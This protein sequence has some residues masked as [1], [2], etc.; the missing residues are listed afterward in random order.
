MTSEN[1]LPPPV[2]SDHHHHHH[3]HHLHHI[4]VDPSDEEDED[5]NSGYNPPITKDEL[6]QE[7]DELL[8]AFCSDAQQQFCM[9]Q[10]IIL[11]DDLMRMRQTVQQIQT[12]LP[13]VNR[14][15]NLQL[16]RALVRSIHDILQHYGDAC[17]QRRMR[18]LDEVLT[19][20]YI[21]DWHRLKQ[22]WDLKNRENQHIL[23]ILQDIDILIQSWHRH[24]HNHQGTGNKNNL[25]LLPSL[26]T[27]L[28]HRLSSATK[29]N[30]S[31]GNNN[32]KPST[33]AAAAPPPPPLPPFSSSL[34]K[35]SSTAEEILTSILTTFDYPPG[36]YTVIIDKHNYGQLGLLHGKIGTRQIIFDSHKLSSNDIIE[37]VTQLCDIFASLFA[38][39]AHHHLAQ[40]DSQ[41]RKA[42][43]FYTLTQIKR[44]SAR[45]F[46]MGGATSTIMEDGDYDLNEYNDERDDM[47]HH[48]TST[49]DAQ[50]PTRLHPVPDP[51]PPGSIARP[52]SSSSM[53]VLT[54]FRLTMTTPHMLRHIPIP[55]P[56]F[57][58][59]PW[60]LPDL[61]KPRYPYNSLF[62]GLIRRRTHCNSNNST[63]NSSNSPASRQKQ[64]STF[65]KHAQQAPGR[66][67]STNRG[68]N[69]GHYR[70]TT[71]N[72]NGIN[73]NASSTS[74]APLNCHAS[75]TTIIDEGIDN[76]P[77]QPRPS[78]SMAATP[79]QRHGSKLSRTKHLVSSAF[80][81]NNTTMT[82]CD[83]WENSPYNDSTTTTSSVAPFTSV[84]V[85]KLAFHLG[86]IA[87]QFYQ[88]L[89][90]HTRMR[91][92]ETQTTLESLEWQMMDLYRHLQLASSRA[93]MHRAMIIV[94][95][96][97]ERQQH[98]GDLQ[99]NYYQRYPMYQHDPTGQEEGDEEDS[100]ELDG[101][102]LASQWNPICTEKS[103]GK[104]R[105][106]NNNSSGT[107]T[108]ATT[109]LSSNDPADETHVYPSLPTTI[110][111]KPTH[112][113]TTIHTN[114]QEDLP[115]QSDTTSQEMS[116]LKNESTL[117]KP[118]QQQPNNP[119]LSITSSFRTAPSGLV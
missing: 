82:Y 108:T 18:L 24:Q 65:L 67:A 77:V 89:L 42:Q 5:N 10:G 110:T 47:A 61:L 37:T 45:I 36:A 13:T 53:A 44:L 58:P 98:L 85:E 43:P 119:A 90:M 78:I 118:L 71:G 95:E 75:P 96:L 35:L 72:N 109:I 21:G 88:D 55:I 70:T 4:A 23:L 83:D 84:S 15:N 113:S 62:F 102:Q 91:Y 104:K 81:G 17:Q 106:N 100:D 103:S 16:R 54:P 27:I 69:S 93:V 68:Y 64:Q 116:S 73:K 51:L 79:L 101:Q 22:Q 39:T 46:D 8:T 32:K 80:N 56:S 117:E 7:L 31:G 115:S 19:N 60:Q 41:I 26:S 107:T 63:I 114:H 59:A 30:S 20:Q 66:R 1:G 111:P 57:V 52:L 86:K 49:F 76:G 112:S 34:V 11:P 9:D 97:D 2:T 28:P 40:I 99:Q 94:H 25:T 6:Y 38:S 33:A 105:D 3:H 12:L 14:N 48:D 87:G 50:H 29:R 74:P 92:Q